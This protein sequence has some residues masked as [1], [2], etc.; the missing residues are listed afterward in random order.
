MDD[1]LN[2]PALPPQREPELELNVREQLDSVRHLTIS[3]M[4]LM[5]IIAGA[6]D[7]FILRQY[8]N[9]SQELGAAHAQVDVAL[10]NWQKI[11]QPAIDNF[12]QELS[13]YAQA[14]QDLNPILM[15]YGLR[16]ASNT[17]SPMTLPTGGVTPSAPSLKK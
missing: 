16:P 11:E 2:K 1:P 12:L 14:H 4:V 15:K 3:A 8:K 10:G 17:V 7:L 5:L 13:K 6:F 9:E